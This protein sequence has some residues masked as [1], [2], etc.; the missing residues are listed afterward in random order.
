MET[1]V[2]YNRI[3]GQNMHLDLSYPRASNGPLPAVLFIH[4]GGWQVG[5]REHVHEM[6]RMTSMRGFIGVGL[7]YR[8]AV[9]DENR[10]PAAV[11]D[12]RCAVRWLRQNAIDQAI[13]PDR[14]GV[15]GFS[16]G[17]HIAAMLGTADDVGGLDQLCGDLEAS[18]R[19]QA[20]VA[21]FAPHD[22]RTTEGLLPR[23]QRI[24]KEFL[25]AEPSARPD[26]ASLASPIA[27]VT[28]GDA[29]MLLVHGD[30]DWV[31]PVVQSRQMLYALQR[32]SIPS[33]LIEVPGAGHGFTMLRTDPA[34]RSAACTS[35]QF[36]EDYL[37]NRSTQ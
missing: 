26:L 36:L 20:V 23:A 27:H 11:A 21:Y 19:V 18:P 16:A 1:N 37:G 17:G 8:L 30:R 34:M 10:F 28:P 32:A 29:P 2:I 15:V 12:A 4:G 24:L 33:H 3:Q 6:M 13:D 35:L 5:R 7:E 31:V 9:R 14:I 22:L 25:G